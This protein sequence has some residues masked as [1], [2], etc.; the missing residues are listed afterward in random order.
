MSHRD[1]LSGLFI[2]L[3]FLLPPSFGSAIE[4]VPS[5]GARE[6]ALSLSV[7][8]LP[9]SFSV[10]HNQAFLTEYKNYAASISYRQPYF[11]QG[12]SQS[13]LSFVCPIQASVLAVGVTQS[14]IGEYKESSIGISIA[15]RL[16]EKLSAGILINFFDLNFPEE[17]AHKGSIQVDGGIGYRL[18]NRLSLGFHLRNIVQSKIETFQ[19]NLSFPLIVRLG[20]SFMLSEQI[21]MAVEA[22]FDN[23]NRLNFRNG[24][25]YKLL[26]C[27]WLRGGV[28]VKP[29]QHSFG[30]G[31]SWN[32]FQLDFAMVHHEILGFTPTFSININIHK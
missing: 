24:L 13:A 15:Q 3:I 31:Y 5:T 17:G 9:G 27:F 2:K 25:E 6:S 21:L 1:V 22:V 14:S 11:I 4:R 19:Y 28:S 8:A 30:L 20:A 26:E 16:S 10:F 29:F 12:Y 18:S 32:L 7:V 23:E